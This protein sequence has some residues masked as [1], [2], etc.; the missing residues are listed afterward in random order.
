MG[1]FTVSEFFFVRSWCYLRSVNCFRFQVLFVLLV[2]IV[3]AA[4]CSPFDDSDP[5][6]NGYGA[7]ED[8]SPSA[9]R[10]FFLLKLKKLKL[11]KLLLG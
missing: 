3:I 11:K 10:Q 9:D 2:F 1:K 6:Y 7:D 8:N 4:M 5:T